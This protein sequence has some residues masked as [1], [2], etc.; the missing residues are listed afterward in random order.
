MYK[1]R[2][3]HTM[4]K[5]GQGLEAQ[6]FGFQT[7]AS[8]KR[9]YLWLEFF[10]NVK[11]LHVAFIWNWHD[12][13]KLIWKINEVTEARR[14]GRHVFVSVKSREQFINTVI[15]ASRKWRALR[16]NCS[17]VWRPMMY[18]RYATLADRWCINYHVGIP[19]CVCVS[20]GQIG[21]RCGRK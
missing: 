5:T 10:Q 17:R 8:S 1:N 16:C 6:W 4:G 7:I 14:V 19:V 13:P 2:M 3:A 12:S 21:T 18:D 15:T 9:I 11:T 20:E